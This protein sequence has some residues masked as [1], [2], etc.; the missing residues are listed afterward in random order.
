[1]TPTR[2]ADG[3]QR[4]DQL[5]GSQ[6]VERVSREYSVDARLLLAF[7]EHFA[8]LVSS[9]DVDEETQLYPILAPAPSSE[10]CGAGFTIN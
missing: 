8:Q 2:L 3:T 9:P 6:I 4:E 1:M 5:S 7:L 10:Y